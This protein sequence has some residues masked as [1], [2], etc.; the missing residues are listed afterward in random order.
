M[1][2]IQRPRVLFFGGGGGASQGRVM[3]VD[4]GTTDGGASYAFKALSNPITA[5]QPSVEIAAYST[6]IF[7]TATDLDAPGYTNSLTLAVRLYVDD[8]PPIL[9]QIVVP[10]AQN[11]RHWPFQ[12]AW[13]VPVLDSG[14]VE[15]GTL[16]PRGFRMQVELESLGTLPPGRVVIDGVETEMEALGDTITAVAR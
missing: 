12:V 6:W 7:I 1:P 3:L 2:D 4:S 13:S 14:G 9:R 8:L 16:A 11:E 5:A 15:Q 10:P